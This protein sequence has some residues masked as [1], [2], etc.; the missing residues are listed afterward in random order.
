M[1]LQWKQETST[2]KEAIDQE[3][4]NCWIFVQSC[5]RAPTMK[6]DVTEPIAN[7]VV[8][9]PT[10]RE[11]QDNDGT[12][13]KETVMT[14]H[15]SRAPS[16]VGSSFSNAVDASNNNESNKMSQSSRLPK[17]KPNGDRRGHSRATCE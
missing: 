5:S 1:A 16:I 7:N 17:S 8:S 6:Q 12:A 2:N 3:Q 4:V 13:M 15:Q 9:T 14:S 11:N 10:A